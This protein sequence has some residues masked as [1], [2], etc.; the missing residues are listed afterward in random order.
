MP[1][2]KRISP[3]VQ[4]FIGQLRTF[5]VAEGIA[6][7]PCFDLWIWEATRLKRPEQ[8][9]SNVTSI[10][11]ALKKA[12]VRRRRGERRGYDHARR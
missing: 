12:R 5:F 2:T 9:R 8:R 6:T 3:A 7:E 4:E 11:R 10:V 1:S